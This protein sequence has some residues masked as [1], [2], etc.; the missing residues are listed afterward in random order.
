MNPSESTSTG[1]GPYELVIFKKL[2]DALSFYFTPL[3]Y[4]DTGY[5]DY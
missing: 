1:L 4:I 2:W 3:E 5:S